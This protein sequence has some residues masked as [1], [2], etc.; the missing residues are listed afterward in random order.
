MPRM[1]RIIT[2]GVLAYLAAMFPGI[3][4]Q[5]VNDPEFSAQVAHPAFVRMHPRV[6]IDESHK[7]F[8]TRNGRY[9]PFAALMETDGFAVSAAPAFAAAAL[10]GVDILVIANAMGEPRGENRMDAAFTTAECNAVRD[11]VRNGG[12]LLLIAD[13][14]PWG[15]ASFIMAQRFGIEMGRGFAMDVRNSDGNPTKL[16]FSRE[17]GLL[18]RHA[19]LRGRNSEEEIRK[20]VAFTGQS[21]TVPRGATVLLQISD[22]ARESF[23]PQDQLKI[24]AGI[25]VGTKLVGRA[26]GIAM[27]FGKGRVAVFGEAAMF[28]AQVAT[29]NGQSFKA[30]MNVPGNDDRQ[31]ALNVMHWLARLI[32]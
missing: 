20:V 23:D 7:N 9:Q 22:D 8:H 3:A 2:V 12:S 4:Q 26:Q 32:N 14:A 6:G 25:P 13:H 30:G 17:N 15:D 10:N 5:Q 19:I 31:F 27:S 11:W 1:F 24:E 18:G 28:S 21:L 16:V 29:L